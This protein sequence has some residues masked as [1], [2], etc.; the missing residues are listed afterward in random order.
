MNADKV[1]KNH[2]AF[3]EDLANAFKTGTFRFRDP[4]NI[5]R[6]VVTRI[7]KQCSFRA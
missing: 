6:R 1:S 4:L 5:D 7:A 3:L 2:D